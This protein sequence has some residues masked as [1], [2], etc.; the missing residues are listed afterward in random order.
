MKVENVVLRKRNEQFGSRLLEF[1]DSDMVTSN[2]DD[3]EDQCALSQ[4]WKYQRKSHTWSRIVGEGS[5]TAGRGPKFSTIKKD[6]L[7]EYQKWRNNEGR[8]SRGITRAKVSR[9][10]SQEGT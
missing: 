1:D 5:S 2:C 10:Y 9:G 4:A 8:T 7:V 3:D 6:E